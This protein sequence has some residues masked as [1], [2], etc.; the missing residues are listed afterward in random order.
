MGFDHESLYSQLLELSS[1]NHYLVAYSGGLD[2]HVLLHAL[3][4]LRKK[5]PQLKLRVIHVNHHF[6]EH[7]VLWEKHCQAICRELEVQLVIGH[8]KELHVPGKSIE[9]ELR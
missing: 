1:S 2:S 8:I 5:Y 9:A 4:F 3:A 6:S 7:A